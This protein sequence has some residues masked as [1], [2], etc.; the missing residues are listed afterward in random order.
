MRFGYKLL[1]ITAAF[2]YSVEVAVLEAPNFPT[3]STAI[4][5]IVLGFGGLAYFE[6]L[7]FL[8]KAGI[9]EG[10]TYR[11]GFRPSTTN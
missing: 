1:M 3:Y 6:A 4:L 11:S 9:S 8:S 10:R 7:V 5:E 2:A